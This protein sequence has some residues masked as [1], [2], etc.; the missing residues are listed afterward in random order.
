MILLYIAAAVLFFSLLFSW[1]ATRHLFDDVI[2]PPYVSRQL[3]AHRKTMDAMQSIEA[4]LATRA[5]IGTEGIINGRPWRR[6]NEDNPI[7]GYQPRFRYNLDLVKIMQLSKMGV[8]SQQEARDAW[9]EA[10]HR[11]DM[12]APDDAD[13][14]ATATL[15]LTPY[16]HQD[17]PDGIVME[18]QMEY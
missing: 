16:P 12:E 15:E 10:Y 18:C 7:F 2:E 9:G 1:Y 14:P 4:E 5:M 8:L 11:M 3:Y 17:A 6:D 13:Y